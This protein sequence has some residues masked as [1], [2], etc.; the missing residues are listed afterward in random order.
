VLKYNI[1]IILSVIVAS[2]SLF[3]IVVAQNDSNNTINTFEDPK[4]GISFQY[5]S[6]WGIASK[7][8]SEALN[9]SV[10][11]M[12]STLSDQQLPDTFTSNVDIYP[13]TLNGAM[14]TITSELLPFPIPLE[15]YMDLT[16]Q[17]IQKM[18]SAV[19]SESIP[20]SIGE[21]NGYKYNIT[22]PENSYN[23]TQILFVKDSKGFVIAFNL[24][25]T[26]QSKNIEDINLIVNSFKIR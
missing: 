5:P 9:K 19:L 8:Y 7:E 13:K 1:A 20:I 18:Y 16:K 4:T 21:V 24:G 14:L 2:F 12:L 25:E 10:D 23:Q 11:K 17:S 6:D 3:Q 22:V 26:E 15:T